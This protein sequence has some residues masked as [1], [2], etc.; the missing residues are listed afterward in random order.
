M[1]KKEPFRKGEKKADFAIN[2]NKKTVLPGT[3]S[4]SDSS[5]H[6][7]HLVLVSQL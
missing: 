5:V 3:M 7:G 1:I 2:M 4:S 6:Y